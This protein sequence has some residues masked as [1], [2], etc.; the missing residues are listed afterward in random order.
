MLRAPEQ[1]ASRSELDDPAEV[2]HGD[3]M[4][5]VLDHREIVR[6]KKVRQVEL[7]LE[8][9]EQVDDLGLHRDIERRH[10]LV[11]DD[12]LRP[13]RKRTRDPEA[14]ALSAGKFVRISRH[15]VGAQADSFEK[16]YHAVAD[17]RYRR[18]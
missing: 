17:F 3:T 4:A 13:R 18:V 9:D 6:D 16:R 2:H 14:L 7:A 10:R 15:L 11:A 1:R 5:D 8:I 12:E